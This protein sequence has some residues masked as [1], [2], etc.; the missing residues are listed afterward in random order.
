M[1]G[2]LASSQ[3]VKV[4]G[5]VK[6]WTLKSPSV[7]MVPPVAVIKVAPVIFSEFDA[8]AFHPLVESTYNKETAIPFVAIV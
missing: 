2:E 4:P 8:T 7:V 3:T 1:V 5:P 6:V